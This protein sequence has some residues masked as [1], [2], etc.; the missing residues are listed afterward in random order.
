MATLRFVDVR[1]EGGV[2]AARGPVR[3]PRCTRPGGRACLEEPPDVRLPTSTSTSSLQRLMGRAWQR[4]GTSRWWTSTT[5]NTSS[6]P[7]SPLAV[8]SPLPCDPSCVWTCA[9]S[10][11]ARER[12][13][14]GVTLRVVSLFLYV[15]QTSA[16]WCCT[17]PRT[18]M[19]SN[20]SSR[21]CTNS[22]SRY[23]HHERLF[24]F[25]RYTDRTRIR[26][27]HAHVPHTH[28]RRLPSSCGG[29]LQVLLNP[30]Y[31]ADTPIT[32]Q[33]FQK[34]VKQLGRKYLT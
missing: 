24:T 13:F 8:R 7:S 19:E 32:S 30:F 18:K 12:V 29:A 9:I 26:H 3:D 4:A 11:C 14:D 16:S 23:S 17:T 28:T 20:T 25:A 10:A 2:A 1:A 33:V 15:H 34:R 6:R 31:K 5:T 21:R 22:T 27:A